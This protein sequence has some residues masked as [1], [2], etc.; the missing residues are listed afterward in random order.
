MAI[1][2]IFTGS[3]TKDEYEKLRNEVDWQRNWAPGAMIHV[4]SFDDAGRIHVADVWESAE[5][6]NAFVEQRLMPA[7]QKLGLAPP[8]VEVYPAHNIDSHSSLSQYQRA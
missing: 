6:L 5:K 7:F 8:N 3:T 1:L 2:A 4:A